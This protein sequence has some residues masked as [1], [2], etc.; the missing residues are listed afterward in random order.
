MIDSTVVKNAIAEAINPAQ[1]EDESMSDDSDSD[2]DAQKKGKSKGKKRDRNLGGLPR[3]CFKKLIKKELDKQCTS[4]FNNLMNCRE[5][6]QNA[7]DQNNEQNKVIHANIICDGCN[8]A[9]IEGVRYKCSVCKNFDFCA[10]CEERRGHEHAFLKIYRPEQAPKALF[11]VVDENVPNCKP[12]IEQQIGE[13]PTYFRNMRGRGGRGGHCGGR[14]GYNNEKYA[15][16]GKMVQEG[17]K[18]FAQG[19]QANQ[20]GFQNQGH[21]DWKIKKATLVSVPAETMIGKPGEMLF[22][23]IEIKNNMNW[24]WKPNAN[25]QSEFT[26]NIAL[27]LDEVAIP[28]DFPVGENSTFKLVIPIKIKESA[29]ISNETYEAQF[30]FVGRSGK[31]F[32]EKIVIKFQVQK[33][34]D[35]VLFYQSAM[36]L[37][38]K[39]GQKNEMSFEEIVKILKDSRNNMTLAKEMIASKKK[40]SEKPEENNMEF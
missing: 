6:G 30:G 3:K 8:K 35:E 24:P 33:E 34:I 4:I 16:L 36:E 1:K 19:Y 7:A 25:L 21:G 37:F 9:P 31:P 40:D 29:K 14:G 18:A 5:I 15:D 10:M 13:N 39:Q 28:I 2:T 17:M 22:A 32:G 23:N 26:Q 11:T 12:D 20:G 38:E 27:M